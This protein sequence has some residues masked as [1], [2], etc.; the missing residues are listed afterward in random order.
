[1]DYLEVLVNVEFELDSQ[2][3]KPRFQVWFADGHQNNMLV[4]PPT[5]ST[6]G[7]PAS[8]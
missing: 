7:F 1:M 8:D 4:A 3:L 5:T 2:C 6:A